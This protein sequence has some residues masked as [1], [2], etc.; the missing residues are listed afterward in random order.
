MLHKKT[1]ALSFC[2]G[3]DSLWEGDPLCLSNCVK[4]LEGDPIIELNF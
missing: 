3:E 4:K 1:D 2:V